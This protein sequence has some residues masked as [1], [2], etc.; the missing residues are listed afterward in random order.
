[1]KNLLIL[2]GSIGKEGEEDWTDLSSEK[3]RRH[4]RVV[5]AKKK[6][7]GEL[8]GTQDEN[9]KRWTQEMRRQVVSK[10]R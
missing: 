1:M 8:R 6:K 9:K 2:K 3:R 7:S 10:K 4:S 5:F